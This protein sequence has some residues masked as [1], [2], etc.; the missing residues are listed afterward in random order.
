MGSISFVSFSIGSFFF[1]KQA[2]R[3]G[4]HKVTC[5]AACLTPLSLAALFFGAKPLGLT[6]I[7]VVF[8]L[9]GLSYNPR[10]STAYLYG[11][12]ML[13]VNKRL[14]YGSILFFLDGCFSVFASYYFY[15][16]KNQ[17][18]FFSIVFCVF[19]TALLIMII[20]LPETPSFLLMKGDVAGY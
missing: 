3:I 6:F 15:T 16:W 7:Y 14:L 12:E 10:G 13:P 5:I 2:D 11:A 4:R 8:G 20:F 1:T 19:T 9:L 18:L 17:N